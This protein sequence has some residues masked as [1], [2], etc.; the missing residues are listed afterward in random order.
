MRSAT[1]R[2]IQIAIRAGGGIEGRILEMLKHCFLI[3]VSV[4][5]VVKQPKNEVTIKSFFLKRTR[6]EEEEK[7]QNTKKGFDN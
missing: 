5:A 7:E 3:S 1:R 4:N 2:T 6:K